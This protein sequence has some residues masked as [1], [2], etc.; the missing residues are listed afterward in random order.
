MGFTGK[1]DDGRGLLPELNFD[2]SNLDITEFSKNDL[3]SP[4]NFRQKVSHELRTN[5]DF[6]FVSFSKFSSSSLSRP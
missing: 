2:F 3:F 6:S 1:K 5:L 4:F